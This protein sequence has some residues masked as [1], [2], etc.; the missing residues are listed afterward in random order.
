MA[1]RWDLGELESQ[2]ER[3]DCLKLGS[4]RSFEGHWNGYLGSERHSN[5]LK[6]TQQSGG[7]AEVWLPSKLEHFS[8][9]KSRTLPTSHPNIS[10]GG[11]EFTQT[12]R[13]L[14]FGPKGNQIS[15]H[16]CIFIWNFYVSE[17]AFYF[18][19]LCFIHTYIYIYICIYTHTLL[20]HFSHV[21]LCVTP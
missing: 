12:F 15:S 2:S 14:V 6:V 16:F 4:D 19:I 5:S 7:R 17:F 21:R 10:S 18:V 11:E 1:K 3:N 8:C 20:S 13:G 9:S